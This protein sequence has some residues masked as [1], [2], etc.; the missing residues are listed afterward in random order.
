MKVRICPC[1]KLAEILVKEKTIPANTGGAREIC[2]MLGS[3][4][5]GEVGGLHLEKYLWSSPELF[6]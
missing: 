4:W 6:P 5:Q 1:K 3:L 2:R